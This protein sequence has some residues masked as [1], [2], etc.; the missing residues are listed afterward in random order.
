MKF[1]QLQEVKVSDTRSIVISKA[2]NGSYTIGNR[3][4]V[5]EN[6]RKIEMFTKG[7]IICPDLGVIKQL[8]EALEDVAYIESK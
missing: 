2:D 5:N 3:I 4:A 1:E 8:R 7:A 6:G